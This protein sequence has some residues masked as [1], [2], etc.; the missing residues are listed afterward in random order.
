MS[1]YRV[2]PCHCCRLLQSTQAVTIPFNSCL[3]HKLPC[4]LVSMLYTACTLFWY[5]DKC[6]RMLHWTWLLPLIIYFQISLQPS[7]AM[8]HCW[9]D[10]KT[11]IADMITV[12]GF[13]N[14]ISVQRHDTT[15]KGSLPSAQCFSSPLPLAHQMSHAWLAFFWLCLYFWTDCWE[16]ERLQ[17]VILTWY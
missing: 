16:S 17:Q 14:C 6:A 11:P 1:K 15:E 5:W 4:R 9:H 3:S 2:S 12:T 7:F 13:Q 10:L 8:S